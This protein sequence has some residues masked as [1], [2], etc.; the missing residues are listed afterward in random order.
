MNTAEIFS[1]FKRQPWLITHSADSVFEL[2]R[3]VSAS[4]GTAFL[5]VTHNLNLARRCDQTIELIDACIVPG[6]KNIKHIK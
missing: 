2:M 6:Q 1:R 3:E 5:L 4:S